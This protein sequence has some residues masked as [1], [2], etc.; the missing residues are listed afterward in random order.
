MT[1]KRNIDLLFITACISTSLVLILVGT[2]V[3]MVV[4][5]DRISRY[6]KEN[7]RV[8]VVLSEGCS[9][10]DRLALEEKISA[11]KY[12]NSL[13]YISKDRALET[14][15]QALGVN[16]VDF[17]DYNP[18]YA[19]YNLTLHSD[20]ANND[21]L[22]HIEQNLLDERIVFDVNYQ[23]Q[24]INIVEDNINKIS[25]ILLCIALLFSL[26]SFSLI[27]NTI[28]LTIYSQRFL[29]YSM[30]LVGAK[31]SFIRRPFLRR[32]VM[33][34]AISSIVSCGIIYAALVILSNWE[35]MVGILMNP[36]L[37]GVV[38]VAVLAVGMFITWLCAFCSVNKFLRMKSGELYCI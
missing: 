26:V 37:L 21:S 34:G 10:S 29:L 12:C 11:Q 13:E 19:S 18:F 35:P 22:A 9:A 16:P 15:T 36:H 14:M 23:K 31:W 8:E 38:F 30:K 25:V 17:L 32:N 1:K 20:Y 24:L 4:G 33:V 27:N 6:I 28:K 3:F 7:M 2:W 5:A